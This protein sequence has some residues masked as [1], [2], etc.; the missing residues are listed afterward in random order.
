MNR[1]PRLRPRGYG[2]GW[3][4]RIEKQKAEVGSEEAELPERDAQRL[5]ADKP[6]ERALG[7]SYIEMTKTGDKRA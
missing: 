4:A 6:D 7:F 2:G 3:G 1:Q 5:D